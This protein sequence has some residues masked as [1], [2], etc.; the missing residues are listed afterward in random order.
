VRAIARVDRR[1][2]WQRALAARGALRVA[3]L[4]AAVQDVSGCLPRKL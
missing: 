3:S 4:A 2:L 1:C